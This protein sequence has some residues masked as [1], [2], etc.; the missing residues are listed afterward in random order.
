[1]KL[2]LTEP[3]SREHMPR[4][5][6]I[7]AAAYFGREALGSARV[8]N[9]K[10][11]PDDFG[12][13]QAMTGFEPGYRNIVDYIV[14]ITHRIWEEGEIE[15]IGQTYAEDSLVFDDT[16]LQVGNVVIIDNT[17]ATI[18][19]SP[20]IQLSADE[21]IW[22]GDAEVGFHTSHRLSIA[23]TRGGRAFSVATIANCVVRDNA[24]YLEHVLYETAEK[25]RQTGRDPWVEAHAALEA[26]VPGFPRDEQT[27]EALRGATRNVCERAAGFDADAFARAHAGDIMQDVD[28]EGA[29][30][31]APFSEFSLA[32]DDVYWMGSDADGYLISVRVSAEPMH[33]H[34]GWLREPTGRQLQFWGLVQMRVADGALVEAWALVNEYDLI[35]QVSR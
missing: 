22:A 28:V 6:A 29:P 7:S 18:A 4:D 20:D 10:R 19:E 34:A 14:R 27:W 35:L 24:I 16:G 2:P 11:V 25:M 30:L 17:K 33:A 31:L 1:M 3:L 9:E 15:Y 8:I 12:P 13:A 5:R 32:V 26:G 23:G 21:I